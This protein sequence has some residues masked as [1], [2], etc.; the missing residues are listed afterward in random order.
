MKGGVNMEI[1][2]EKTESTMS[3]CVVGYAAAFFLLLTMVFVYVEKIIDI[4]AIPIIAGILFAFTT[5]YLLI[6]TYFCG[7]DIG[8]EDIFEEDNNPC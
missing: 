8:K 1:N 5:I 4:L 2:H 7:K 3:K 6:Q